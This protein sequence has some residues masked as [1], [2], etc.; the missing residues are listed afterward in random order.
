MPRAPTKTA[1]RSVREES[2]AVY[3]KAIV[4]AA[5]RVFGQTGYH[6]AKIADIAA[7]AGVATGTLYN[8]FTS[9]EEIFQSILEDGVLVMTEEVAR[10]S[11]ISDPL[12]RMREVIRGMFAFLEDNGVLF[13]IHVQLGANPMD[14]RRDPQVDDEAFRRRLLALFEDS[15]RE[16]GERVRADPPADVLAWTLAGMMHG[17]ILRWLDGGC[18]APLRGTADT[19]MDLF[20]QGA[21][22]R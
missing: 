3:R 9:K 11:Q 4:D 7:E 5:V 6:E 14:L 12:L 20:L 2:R 10:L 18:K 15:L 17:A 13:I 1:R 22:P 16:A 21:T 8:Y 19:I